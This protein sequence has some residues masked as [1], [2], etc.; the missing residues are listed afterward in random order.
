MNTPTMRD[1][2][3]L[4]AYLDRELNQAEK[5][6]LIA[7]IVK[8]PALARAL[9]DLRQ[10]RSMLRQTPRRKAPRNF[11][12]TPK[13]VGIRPPTPRVVPALSWAS[14]LAT[15]MFIF[16]LGYNFLASGGLSAAAPRAVDSTGLAQAPAATQPPATE[17][18]A[19]QAPVAPSFLQAPTP[20]P[21]TV[22]STVAPELQ[23]RGTPSGKTGIVQ[24]T[25][26]GISGIQGM[27]SGLAGT[28]TPTLEPSRTVTNEPTLQ[29]ASGAN[30]SEPSPPVSRLPLPWAYIWLGLAALLV[31]AALLIRWL[32]RLAFERKTKR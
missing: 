19:T 1:L 2:E 4:S 15:L 7:R 3:L 18:P 24:T 27:G 14:A 12:L 30:P 29:A 31:G 6:R 21:F 25:P 5:T 16:T 28:D 32:N 11:T 10:T 8:E 23:P 20:T 22:V 17:P 26:T 13:M 9:E